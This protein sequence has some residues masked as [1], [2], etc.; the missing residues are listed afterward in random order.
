MFW[1]KKKKFER[2]TH[3]D[4]MDEFEITVFTELKNNSKSILRLTQT[5]LFYVKSDLRRDVIRNAISRMKNTDESQHRDIA[6]DM[7]FELS[8]ISKGFA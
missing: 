8:K 6:D 2:Y 3:Q 5:L 7:L 4:H 1:E